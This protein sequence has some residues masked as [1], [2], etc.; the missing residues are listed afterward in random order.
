MNNRTFSCAIFISFFIVSSSRC[1]LY[2][3]KDKRS[4]QYE[5]YAIKESKTEFELFKKEKAK[6]FETKLSDFL[7]ASGSSRDKKIRD[8]SII[9]VVEKFREKEKPEEIIN[10][11]LGP[12]FIKKR[13][14]NDKLFGVWLWATKKIKNKRLAKL[15]KLYCANPRKFLKIIQGKNNHEK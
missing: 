14:P 12:N 8:G 5:P 3:H 9:G 7:N 6:T 10:F 4:T 13:S 15:M 2:I 11:L 1:S